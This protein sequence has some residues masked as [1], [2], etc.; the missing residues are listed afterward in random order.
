MKYI[1]DSTCPYE[2]DSLNRYLF[3]LYA[4]QNKLDVCEVLEFSER[5]KQSSGRRKNI[6]KE[7]DHL[8]F[9]D[10]EFVIKYKGENIHLKKEFHEYFTHQDLQ[11][12]SYKIEITM[13]SDHWD[14]LNKES[15]NF[16]DYHLHMKDGLPVKILNHSYWEKLKDIRKR[17][18]DSIFIPNKDKNRI[19]EELDDF[20]N[21]EMYE[22]REKLS[23]PHKK[24][25][26]LYGPPGT[27]KTSI[28][29]AI[30]TH[31]KWGI[32]QIP[33]DNKLDSTNLIIGVNRL[34]EQYIVLFEDIDSY[35]LERSIDGNHKI[36]FSDILNILDGVNSP[37]NF[38]VVLTTNHVEKLDEALTRPGRIDCMINITFI[39]KKESK[40]MFNAFFPKHK[41]KF[42]T[43]WKA[44]KNKH[45][46]TGCKLHS[47][48]SYCYKKANY[49]EE[50]EH[51]NKDDK[52]SLSMYT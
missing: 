23:I 27:G 5:C 20:N 41:D 30:A 26:L 48:F 33:I 45:I 4:Q 13:N 42:N 43:F 44:I 35:F 3:Y 38:I 31:L 22:K 15:S 21:V 46:L 34:P 49:M 36:C 47:Y 32:L 24:I 10:G 6:K 11:K 28:A 9:I 1:I 19:I 40:E 37:K 7:T 18:F 29:K 16:V 25:F 8:G 14:S 50:I 12:K 17:S 2:I 39:K 52:T 51:L